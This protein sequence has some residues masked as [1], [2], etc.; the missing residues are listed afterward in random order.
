MAAEP[1]SLK[2]IFDAGVAFMGVMSGAFKGV[3]PPEVPKVWVTLGTATA[4]AAFFSAKL[5]LALDGVPVSRNTWFVFSLAFV[6]LAVA[7]FI[8]YVFTRF[9][10]TITYEGKTMLAGPRSEYLPDVAADPQNAG[11][12]RDQL[13]R[14]AAGDA[15]DVWTADG[16]SRSRRIL[17][18]EYT[19]SITLL[20]FGLYLGIEA[21]NTKP[22]DP[23]PGFAEITS[24]LRDVHFENDQ[25]TPGQDAQDLLKAD[26]DILKDAFRRFNRATLIVEGYCDDLGSDRYNFALGYKRAEAA[27]QALVDDQVDAAKIT[28]TSHGRKDSNCRANDETCRARNRRV[29]LTAVQN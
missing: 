28:V 21:W 11:K 2:L 13:I 7:V 16:I 29:H 4:S 26:A 12:T 20:A 18:L 22:P 25:S 15:G 23:P 5:L 8:V 19:A 24:K 1:L 3:A 10:R 6:W 17:G 14:A 9:S 27:R